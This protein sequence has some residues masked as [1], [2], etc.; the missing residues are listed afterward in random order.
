[1]LSILLFTISYQHSL[2]VNKTTETGKIHRTLYGNH[3]H[4]TVNIK[5][6]RQSVLGSVM[7]HS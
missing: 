7:I 6:I 1:M 5:G 4:I 2:S 3:V